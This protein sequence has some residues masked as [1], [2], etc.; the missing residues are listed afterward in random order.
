[1]F[2]NTLQQL[3]RNYF[4][5]T[6]IEARGFWVWT[7]GM[8]VLLVF[9]FSLS[10]LDTLPTQPAQASAQSLERAFATLESPVG[11]PAQFASLEK[12][13]NVDAV[14]ER[15]MFNPNDASE[16]SLKRLGIPSRFIKS[17]VKF[18]SKGGK[19][20]KKADLQKIYYFPVALYESLE[21]YIDLPTENA[22]PPKYAKQTPNTNNQ[23][24]KNALQPF[25]LNTADTATLSQVRGI[26]TKTAQSIVTYREKLGGFTHLAQL[27]E[28][29]LLQ[30]KPE[31]VAELSRYAL[32]QT[33]AIKI[34]INTASVETLQ[35]HP[36]FRKIAKAL[37]S[38]RTKAGK[39]E[40]VEDLQKLKVVTP[41]VWEKIKNYVVSE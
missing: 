2:L 37:V 12:E 16:E 28:V 9:N 1:M 39:F 19:F 30:N 40:K 6:R 4:G 8:C 27:Q 35:A 41:E 7:V 29:Y 10:Y 33:P 26:G 3:L 36:Y 14:G 38:Y 13:S 20:R 22:R 24:I 15:F 31:V 32:L 11:V 18:R 25:D 5:F 23:A 17:I 34:N 21:P